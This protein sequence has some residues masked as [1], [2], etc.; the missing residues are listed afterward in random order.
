MKSIWSE[1]N[2]LEFEELKKDIRTEVLVIG[3]G[4]SG[5]L[6]AYFLRKSGKEVVLLEADKICSKKSKKTTAVVTALQDAMYHK[7]PQETAKLFLSANLFAVN[8]YKKLSKE[9]D[10]D[11]EECSS[12]KYSKQSNEIEKEYAVLKL[13]GAK[14]NY[15]DDIGIPVSFKRAIEMKN[16]GQFNPIKLVD[17][18]SRRLVIFEKSPV[19]KIKKNIAYTDK[20]K[21]EFEQVVVATGY[22]FLKLKGLFPVKLHQQK[23]HV[24][25]IET[26]TKIVGNG[27]GT[28]P[29]DIY[30]RNYKNKLILGCCDIKTGTDCKGFEEINSFILKNYNIKKVQCKWINEDTVSLDELPY[31]G[32]YGKSKNMFI[33]TGYNLW[34][35]SASMLGAHII[36][37]LINGRENKFST[38][39]S[40]SRKVLI[41]PLFENVKTAVKNL[42]SFGGPRCSHLGCKLHYNQEDSTYECMCH[43]SKYD[44]KGNVIETPAQKSINI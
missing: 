21:V 11:F 8:E 40:P 27:I 16:Q 39:F 28:S 36:T 19:R 24:I 14:V 3:G 25:S 17:E 23:S 6:C 12:Y 15:V 38:I 33:S 44:L 37:D 32:R 2:T 42:F 30:F 20:Y 34:G 13:L 43:G 22:P 5:V 35:M 10:F 7:F 26:D 18:L 41:K 1:Y 31:I 4:I 29:L 9:Y